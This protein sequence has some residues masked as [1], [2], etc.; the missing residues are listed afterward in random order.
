MKNLNPVLRKILRQRYLGEQVSGVVRQAE[1][2]AL[3][4]AGQAA[5]QG[6]KEAV[7]RGLKTI[8]NEILEKIFNNLQLKS[9]DDVLQTAEGAA[10][11]KG[12]DDEISNLIDKNIGTFTDPEELSKK[13]FVDLFNE[14]QLGDFAQNRKNFSL[15]KE[16]D[17]KVKQRTSELFQESEIESELLGAAETPSV[18]SGAKPN[19]RPGFRPSPKPPSEVPATP[20]TTPKTTPK[21]GG[22]EEGA[23]TLGTIKD[24]GIAA[25]PI[26]LLALAASRMSSGGQDVERRQEKD[27]EEEIEMDRKREKD[28]DPFKS[29][30]ED[31]DNRLFKGKLGQYGGYYYAQ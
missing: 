31:I 17:A 2:A 6:A 29:E 18:E 8:D 12:L 15:I 7:K 3:R 19:V 9:L 21:T 22:A 26:A 24:I 27:Q 5:R 23:P 11:V 30:N 20:G 16:I 14:T 28:I 10:F 13:V 1:Q 25:T 4:G